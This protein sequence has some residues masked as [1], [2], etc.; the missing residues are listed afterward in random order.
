MVPGWRETE[1]V[2]G[3]EAQ[4]S[5]A[6]HLASPRLGPQALCPADVPCGGPVVSGNCPGLARGEESPAEAETH[7]HDG[8]REGHKAGDTRTELLQP[9]KFFRG[10]DE[11]KLI[12]TKP[13]ALC[14]ADPLASRQK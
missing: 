13:A 9:L 7:A 4:A 8:P 5:Q 2:C 1:Q 3:G 6:G 14:L 10:E 11:G 12:K